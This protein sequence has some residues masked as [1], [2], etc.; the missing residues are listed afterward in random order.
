MN[1]PNNTKKEILEEF[2]GYMRHLI[3]PQ[4]NQFS[5]D[6]SSALDRIEAET[7]KRMLE[8]VNKMIATIEASDRP[9]NSIVLH[10][11]LALLSK[12]E[13]QQEND[14]LV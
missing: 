2:N 5:L 11:L 1:Q 9:E 13:P 7:Q 12:K 14:G 3:L 6:L 8:V 4:R 10:N